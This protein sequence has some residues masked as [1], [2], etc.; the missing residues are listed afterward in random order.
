M[1]AGDDGA[2]ALI[3]AA[4]LAAIHLFASRL[5]CLRSPPRSVWLSF[6]GGAALAYTFVHL[7]PELA[8]GGERTGIYDSLGGSI[9][10]A[11]SF[12]LGGL[13]AFYTL[14]QA[15][16]GEQRR[17]GRDHLDPGT[18]VFWLHLSSFTAYNALIGYLLVQ[19]SREGAW[20]F[21]TFVAAMSF[22][23]LVNDRG[24]QARHGAHYPRLSRFLLAGA[25]LLPGWLL[26][27]LLPARGLGLAL[28]FALLAGGAILN[29]LKEEL[30]RER[31]SRAAP[32]AVGAALYA[33]IL[34]FGSLSRGP[35]A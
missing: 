9:L 7:L 14:E 21:G 17:R 23:L 29:L 11:H 6:A 32:F 15:V 33:V 26:G 35:G 5:D 10:L 27:W 31:R 25:V 20:S 12:V 24:L 3:A 8:I 30:P 13:I 2:A 28:L 34:I 19:R 18:P 1:E 22:N 4:W 16:A